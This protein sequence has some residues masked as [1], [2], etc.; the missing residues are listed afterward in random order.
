MCQPGTE[1]IPVFHITHVENLAPIL[2]QGGLASHKGCIRQG[3]TYRRIGNA[4]LKDTRSAFRVRVPP[5]G[6]LGDYVPFYLGPLS[7]MQY[8]IH[9]KTVAGYDGTEHDIVSLVSSVE[10]LRRERFAFVHT[11]GQ[12]NAAFTKHVAGLDEIAS[13]VDW[14][15]IRGRYWNNTDAYPDR[16]RR[17]LAEVLVHTP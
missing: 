10:V 17:R 4:A 12:A 9:C 6:F 16:M 11:D 15:V 5:H 14:L 2:E 13:T 1:C 7:P 8:R 3:L